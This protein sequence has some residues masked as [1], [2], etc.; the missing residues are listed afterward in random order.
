[1]DAAIVIA[2]LLLSFGGWHADGFL[3]EV[4]IPLSV[5]PS[6]TIPVEIQTRIGG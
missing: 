3:L 1:M 4:S 5:I 6:F 2:V